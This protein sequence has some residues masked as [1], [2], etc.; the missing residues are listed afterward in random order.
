V[1]GTGPDGSSTVVSNGSVPITSEDDVSIVIGALT[2]SDELVSGMDVYLATS[3]RLLQATASTSF[4]GVAIFQ[5]LPAGAKYDYTLFDG[6]SIRAMGRDIEVQAG[7][8][9]LRRVVVTPGLQ[10]DSHLEGVFS[11]STGSPGVFGGRKV[12]SLLGE[13]ADGMR[14]DNRLDDGPMTAA[15]LRLSLREGDNQSVELLRTGADWVGLIDLDQT[16]QLATLGVFRTYGGGEQYATFVDL[17]IVAPSSVTDR[18]GTPLPDARVTLESS[19]SPDGPFTPVS[20]D[21]LHYATDRN[22][23]PTDDRGRFGFLVTDPR[24]WFRATTT[25][26]GVTASSAVVQGQFAADALS[27]VVDTS[28]RPVA[29]NVSP[30]QLA[31]TGADAGS[32]PL[33]GL[34][35]LAGAALLLGRRVGRRA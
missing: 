6:S 21:D 14:D 10:K 35:L 9:T 17:A 20:V 12:F 11:G 8:E 3:D 18:R 7:E 24:A 13:Q 30:T 31:A 22:P 32:W 19:D 34:L 1:T 27:I 29:P 4:R 28:G 16:P 26:D 2:P 25:V 23:A 33:G 15:E 5:G